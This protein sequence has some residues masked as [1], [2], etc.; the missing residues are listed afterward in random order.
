M[1]KDG[2]TK[3]ARKCVLNVKRKQNEPGQVQGES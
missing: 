1:G 3:N 2:E